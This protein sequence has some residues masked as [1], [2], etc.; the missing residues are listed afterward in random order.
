[1]T[2]GGEL[3]KLN[4][5]G[6]VRLD[7]KIDSCCRVARLTNSSVLECFCAVIGNSIGEDL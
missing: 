4:W 7:L 3:Y 2:I 1:M 6:E 5:R